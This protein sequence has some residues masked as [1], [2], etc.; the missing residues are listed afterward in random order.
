[1]C[2]LFGPDIYFKVRS[3]ILKSEAAI[4]HVNIVSKKSFHWFSFLDCI[5][6][7]QNVSDIEGKNLHEFGSIKFLLS[8]LKDYQMQLTVDRIDAHW[9]AR[10]YENE[11]SEENANWGRAEIERSE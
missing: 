3:N 1:M 2:E 5:L 10:K 8:F 7:A 4:C 6:N 9:N 11:D